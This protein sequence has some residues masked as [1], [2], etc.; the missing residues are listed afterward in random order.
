LK[1]RQEPMEAL[2]DLENTA[3]VPAPNKASHKDNILRLASWI[4]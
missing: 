4:Y 1:T 3:A 2:Q